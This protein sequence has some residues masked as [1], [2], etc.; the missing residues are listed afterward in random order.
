V[1]WGECS[2][3]NLAPFDRPTLYA[4]ERADG[5]GARL[6][7]II[8]W[9]GVAARSGLNFGGVVTNGICQESH[10]ADIFRAV[11]AVLGLQSP[12]DLFIEFPPEFDREYK[13]VNDFHKKFANGDKKLREYVPT[14]DV[15]VRDN[16]LACELDNRNLSEFL[17]PK[18]LF[19]LR[20]ESKLGGLYKNMT[21]QGRRE[22]RPV[23]AVHVRR[24]DV[25]PGTPFSL[26]TNE[27]DFQRL[28]PDD[29]YFEVVARILKVLPNADVHVFSSTEN[30]YNSS[31]FDGFRQR[32]MT[33]HLDGDILDAWA[34]MAH[35][36][37]LVMAKSAFSHVPAY[38]NTN[39]I[40]FQPWW[41]KPLPGWI[42]ARDANGTASDDSS[43]GE[44]FF[45]ISELRNCLGRADR[46]SQT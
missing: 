1:A 41:H 4:K 27:H 26:F 44:P 2:I 46:L 39:C 38:L 22:H 24:G 19:F 16:C 15:L 3:C 43:R 33:V 18:L 7:E 29:W 42:I 12:T 13:G 21:I 28:S 45:D 8:S 20:Y 34:V 25:R 37:V 36:N 40:L 17:S 10:G 23:V 31:D 30:K 9:A 6:Q 14:G 5:C 11:S 32:N 35:A